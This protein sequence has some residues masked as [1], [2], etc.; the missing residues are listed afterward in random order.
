MAKK[1]ESENGS[2][3]ALKEC[4][5]CGGKA[6]MRTERGEFQEGRRVA[7]SSLTCGVSTPLV[8]RRKLEGE[9]ITAEDLAAKIWNTRK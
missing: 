2:A 8:F 1:N 7:C 6:E 9:P 3:A 5:M 4:P